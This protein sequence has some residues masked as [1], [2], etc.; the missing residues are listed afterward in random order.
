MSDS[1]SGGE[2]TNAEYYKD[3]WS[4]P[5]KVKTEHKQAKPKRH[6]EVKHLPQQRKSKI[7]G[8]KAVRPPPPPNR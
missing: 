2:H 7:V 6:G 3:L 1:E 4:K 8:R 5:P